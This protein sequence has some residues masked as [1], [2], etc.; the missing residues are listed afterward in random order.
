MKPD[1]E[2]AKSF[3]NIP[4]Y[5]FAEIDRMIE[6]A[7]KDGV[8]VIN[9]G[10]GDPDLPTPD[11]LIE[12]MQKEVADPSTHGYPDYLGNSDF[13]ESVADWYKERFSVQLDPKREI[14]SL[15]GSKEGLAHLPLC[16]INRGD[17]A[18]IPDPGYPVYETSIIMAGGEP[19]SV[20]LRPENDYLVDFSEIGNEILQ[21]A[22]F[23]FLNYPNNPTG[24]VADLDFYREAA[25][26][27]KKYNFFIIHDAAYSEIGLDGFTPPSFLEVEGGK[28]VAI[29]F[30]SLSKT[31]NMTGW[32]LGWALGNEE[33]VE[34]LGTI[35][36]NI[37]SGVFEAIQRTGTAALRGDKTC[38]Q[39]ARKVYKRRRDLLVNGLKKLGL[40]AKPNRGAF[41]MW[42]KIPSGYE[43]SQEFSR[44]VFEKTGVFFTPG[45]GYGDQGKNY[46]RIA[47][48]VTRDTIKE[49]V[50][51][52]DRHFD[53]S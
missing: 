5:M 44:E 16:F 45:I 24:A 39:N 38:T 42:V 31:F 3:K 6:K 32:R 37:D 29:E 25:A 48:T 18:L 52:L 2:K 35:K 34:A 4:P 30:G 33:L 36:T 50:D 20:P 12:I 47:L 11:H 49:A 7:K 1:V 10:M 15:I 17:K 23:I 21:Q 22:K 8:D 26:R 43:N 27:A 40:P 28:Q 53:W 14:I 19:V 51:R 41:Y 13:R 46:V 9:F